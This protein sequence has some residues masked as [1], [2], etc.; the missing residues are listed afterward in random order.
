VTATSPSQTNPWS[1]DLLLLAIAF[2][3]LYFFALGRAPLGSQDE[4]RYSEIPREMVASGDWVTPRLDGVDYFEKPPLVYWAVAVCMEAFGPGETSMRTVPALFSVSGILLT[5]A[6]ARRLYGREAGLA[7]A[8]VLGTCLLYFAIGHILLLDMAMTVLMSATLFCFLLGVREPAAPTGWNR[9]R[10]LF[11]GLYA[12]A[13]LATLTKGLIGFLVTGAVML[14]WLVLFDQWK[15]LRPLYLPTGLPLFLV[16]AAPWHLL[17]A[18]RNPTWAHRYFVYEHWLR[19]FTPAAGRHGAWWYF[20]PIVLFGLFPWVGFLWP[21]L[22]DSLRGGW[23]RR[24]E[25]AAAWFLVTWAA[26]IFL[27][28]SKSQSKLAP[29]ILPVFPPLAVIVGAWLAGEGKDLAKLRGGLRIFS[30]VCGLLGAAILVAVL[31]VG[32]IIKDPIQALELRPFAFVLAPCLVLGGALTPVLA[33]RG[34]RAAY[35]GVAATM[36]CLFGVVSWARPAIDKPGTKP[37]A[38]DMRVWVE[39][40]DEVVHYHEFFP[41]FMFYAARVVDVV[42]FK[43]ELELEEDAAARA[44]GRF[45]TEPEFRRRWAGPSRVIA[46][47]RKSDTAELFADPAFHKHLLGETRDYYLFS[48][49]P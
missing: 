19:F 37:L 28:F 22:R 4:G 6:A 42:E 3:A 35:A 31:R 30:F 20:I 2:G 34:R 11:Y 18:S 43:G 21:A 13:A 32:L 5:Y 45:M 40:G 15:R 39:P 17:A 36:A 9:R 46:V 27:F 49:Q 23:A 12:S 48:N 14:L 47:A 16:I 24:R 44:S 8:V 29:Y 33:G 41:D 38:Q 25:N 26:F 7:S 10:A 1:R